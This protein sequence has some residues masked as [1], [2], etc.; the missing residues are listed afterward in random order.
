MHILI[1][2]RNDSNHFGMVTSFVEQ[3][4]TDSNLCDH[5]LNSIEALLD[6]CVFASRG[7]V[8]GLYKSNAGNIYA[9]SMDTENAEIETI[10]F[11]ET[12]KPSPSYSMA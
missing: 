5:E 9:V 3:F 6:Y 11:F 1:T 2:S 7:Y 8:F 12:F 10:E 4:A